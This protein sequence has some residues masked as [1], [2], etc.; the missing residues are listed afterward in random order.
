M[1]SEYDVQAAQLKPGD[2]RNNRPGYAFD[3]EKYGIIT[4]ATSGIGKEFAFQLAQQGLHLIITGRRPEVL[5]GISNELKGRYGIKVIELV[6]DL[7][8]KSDV[9]QLLKIIDG[10]DRIEILVNNAGFGLKEK[11]H[12][13]EIE[14]QLNMLYVHVTSPL[15]LTHK[16]L[17][18]M[19]RAGK[20]TIIN[21]CSMAAY[22]PTEDNAM[23]TGTKSFMLNF[24]ISLQLQL[25][26]LGIRVQCLCPGFTHTDFHK[27]IGFTQ[28]FSQFKWAG[29]MEAG[30]VVRYSLSAIEKGKIL[31]VPGRM[32]RAILAIISILPAGSMYR[33]SGLIRDRFLRRKEEVMHGF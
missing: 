15:I 33:L 8:V 31:C 30:D 6:A 21:V 4:G 22:T 18:K 11:F 28:R 13:D 14:H 16:V 20:G 25:K 9:L 10:I 23:Y 26:H 32:N 2:N 3:P 7:A 12:Q 5:N 1:L 17:D 24:S 29:W 27:N 19:K